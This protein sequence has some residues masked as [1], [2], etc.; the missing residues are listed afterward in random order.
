[1]SARMTDSQPCSTISLLYVITALRSF[2]ADDPKD[3]QLCTSSA[4]YFTAS[5]A[6]T[7]LAALVVRVPS[8]S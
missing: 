1:M 6:F 8:C 5:A 3:F 4:V 7:T 2:G